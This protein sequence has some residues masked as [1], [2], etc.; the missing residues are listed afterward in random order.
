MYRIIYSA[1][2]ANFLRKAQLKLQKRFKAKIEHLAQ[3][4]FAPNHN[5][6]RIKDL[7][8]GYR[9][10]IGDYRVT[11]ELDTQFRTILVWKIAPRSSIYKP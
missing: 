3:D 1:Q 6:D 2:A 9:L 4:P 5:L 11:Y 7:P 8:H 10:R